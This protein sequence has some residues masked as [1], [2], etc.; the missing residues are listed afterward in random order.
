MGGATAA[1]ENW[2]H[3]LGFIILTI[4]SI[5]SVFAVPAIVGGM[6]GLR[7]GTALIGASIVAAVIALF[8][9]FFWAVPSK[10]VFGEVHVKHT[11]LFLVL[12]VV[13]LIGASFSRPQ[14]A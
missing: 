12:A 5:L 2:E 6:T 10:G 1:L 14:V 4:L 13:A 9:A 11:V 7:R 3:T 8:W